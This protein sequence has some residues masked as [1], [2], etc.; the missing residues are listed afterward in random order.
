M[1]K[2]MIDLDFKEL[3]KI[4]GGN[5]KSEIN[6][7][8]GIAQTFAKKYLKGIIE[9]DIQEKI[10]EEIS[11][12]QQKIIEEIVGKESHTYNGI[13]FTPS[14]TIIKFIHE[15]TEFI[16]K[17]YILKYFKEE[18]KIFFKDIE[19]YYKEETKK[20]IVSMEKENKEMIEDSIEKAIGKIIKKIIK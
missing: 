17:Q 2:I 13:R 3:K 14:K 11:K 4:I 10:I 19:N 9:K 5:T 6:I 18:F 15:K 8:K 1:S 7:R 20:F 16:I 12:K